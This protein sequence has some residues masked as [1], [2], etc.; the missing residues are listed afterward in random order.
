MSTTL[1]P[2]NKKEQ[3]Q[4]THD[5]G[6]IKTSGYGLK[7]SQSIAVTQNGRLVSEEHHMVIET[8]IVRG[9]NV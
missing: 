1:Y 4:N 5:V 7:M 9:N 3:I 2:F 8:E 6:R